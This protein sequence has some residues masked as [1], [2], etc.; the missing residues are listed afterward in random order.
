MD[1]H[2]GISLSPLKPHFKA[3]VS[4]PHTSA[5]YEYSVCGIWLT[6]QAIQDLGSHALTTAVSQVPYSAFM[7]CPDLLSPITLLC[8]PSSCCVACFYDYPCLYVTPPS[9]VLTETTQYI[10][11]PQFVPSSIRSNRCPQSSSFVK[12]SLIQP[13][14]QD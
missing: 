6:Q 14:S 3:N 4:S 5:S 1:T 7:T 13:S 12:L 10:Q 2:T 11:V 9:P 8:R